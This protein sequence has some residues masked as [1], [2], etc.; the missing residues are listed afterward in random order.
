MAKINKSLYSKEEFHRLREEKK[1]KKLQTKYKL[2]K[3]LISEAY[4]DIVWEQ[5]R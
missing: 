1:Q 5:N 2:T 3:E 4:T